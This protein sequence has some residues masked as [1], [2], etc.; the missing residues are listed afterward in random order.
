MKP[1]PEA[2]VFI[3]SRHTIHHNSS[4]F[5]DSGPAM[6]PTPLARRIPC[7]RNDSNAILP[8][9]ITDVRAHAYDIEKIFYKLNVAHGKLYCIMKTKRRWG[10]TCSQAQHNRDGEIA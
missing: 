6:Q 7:T 10:N 9:R 5:H 2:R 3:I 1:V 8:S 4:T